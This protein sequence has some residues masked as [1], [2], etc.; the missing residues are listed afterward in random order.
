MK[1]IMIVVFLFSSV[2]SMAQVQFG[3]KAGANVSNFNGGDFDAVKKKA[4]VGFHGGMYLNFALGDLSLQP[5]LM[6]STQG[7][8]IDSINGSYDWRVTYVNLPV[9]LQYRFESGFFLELGPQVG[10]KISDDMEDQTIKNFAKDLDL[11][12]AGGLGFKSKGGFGVGA[13]YTVGLSKVGDFE[14][15]SNIDPDFKNGVIQASVYF[16]LTKKKK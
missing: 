1:K 15:S 11:S 8:K 6:V 5:E 9:V 4:L 10:F 16:P 3:I 2:V 14:P 12:A 13:R 7:A